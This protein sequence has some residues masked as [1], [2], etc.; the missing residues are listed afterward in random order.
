MTLYRQVK[1]TNLLEYK[2]QSNVVILLLYVLANSVRIAICTTIC[3]EYSA[4][5]GEVIE[6][7]HTV[8]K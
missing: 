5:V 7:W 8:A 1:G 6:D 3:Q 4:D 2:G